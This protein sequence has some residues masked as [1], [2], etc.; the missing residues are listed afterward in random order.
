M[1]FLGGYPPGV[2]D[3]VR[4]LVA[5]GKLGEHLARRYPQ[6]HGVQTDRA[7]YD[8]TNELKQE[9]LRSAPPLHKVGYDARL[10]T[11]HKALGLHTAISRVQGGKLKAKKEIRVASLFK[12]AP[13]EFLRMIVVHELAHLKESDHNKA[14]YRLCE[15]MEP[16]YHQ[17]EFD[18]R[19]FLAWRELGKA[20][21]NASAVE[22]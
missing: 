20:A 17:L 2:L 3:Q 4:D 9:Y 10:D 22:A 19:L 5:T 8:Y 16:H 7:L 13:P 12:E 21:G 1:R 15:H 11:A 14:F 18:T 6:C